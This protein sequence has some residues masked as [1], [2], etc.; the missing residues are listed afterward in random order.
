MR[1]PLLITQWQLF[2]KLTILSELPKE[3]RKKERR[4]ILQCQCWKQVQ[5]DLN[6][7]RSWKT[8]SCWC[9]HKKILSKLKTTHWQTGKK[10]YKTWQ[11][12]KSRCYNKKASDY[13]RYWWIWIV[14]HDSWINSFEQFRKDIPEY[15]PWL[16]IDRIDNSKWYIPWNIKW[17]TN[18]EQQS[19]KW[20]TIFIE[21][22][23]WKK[24]LS[25]LCRE[26][27]WSYNTIYHYRYW[28]K[29]DK[30]V[31]EKLNSIHYKKN[32]L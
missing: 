15:I 23:S 22:W 12:I 18:Q 16:T 1:T 13:H 27:W 3:L 24:S 29:N 19:N 25:N 32:W 30:Q 26:Y 9:E 28:N 31:M 21:T 4:F 5:V 20:N 8:T 14:M 11:W 17:S 10:L 6:H 2:W 7:L